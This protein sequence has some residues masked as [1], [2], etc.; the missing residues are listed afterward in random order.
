MLAKIFPMTDLILALQGNSLTILTKRGS[1]G[2]LSIV[3]QWLSTVEWLSRA[4][5]QYST[6]VSRE[7]RCLK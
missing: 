6:I 4:C 1:I 3:L 7:Y 5:K 2:V